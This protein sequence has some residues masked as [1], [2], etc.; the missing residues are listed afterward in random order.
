MHNVSDS[1]R[2]PN[3]SVGVNTP[4]HQTP[5]K[6]SHLTPKKSPHESEV[7]FNFQPVKVKSQFGSQDSGEGRSKAD[8]GQYSRRDKSNTRKLHKSKKK[9]KSR[10]R[11]SKQ[12]PGIQINQEAYTPVKKSSHGSRRRELGRNDPKNIFNSQF[13]KQWGMNTNQL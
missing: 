11:E 2:S 5:A 13:G 10:R 6:D 1:R 4:Q 8:R 9:H 7:Y 12:Y 3:K